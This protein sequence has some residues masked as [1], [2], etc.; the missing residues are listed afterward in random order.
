MPITDALAPY[1]A[2]PGLSLGIKTGVVDNNGTLT[3]VP[4]Q[5]L[6]LPANIASFVFYDAGAL[7]VSQN[8]SGFP[9]N[10]IPLCTATT[11]FNYISA[12]DDVRPD[13]IVGGG[14]SGGSL[15]DAQFNDGSGG[16]TNADGIFSGSIMAVDAISGEISIFDAGGSDGVF[17]DPGSGTTV[18]CSVSNIVSIQDFGGN[19]VKVGGPASAIDGLQLQATASS[20]SSIVLNSHTLGFYNATPV[21]KP[22]I[23]GAKAGNTAL[24][25]LITQLATLGL[26]TDSTT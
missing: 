5:T 6:T 9:A 19:W 2:G 25:S 23:T 3:I 16:L 15:G 21:V 8:T 11:Q 10:C 26:V 14:G 13:F 7:I 12:F 22:A 4:A 1:I 17:V 18:S 20:T 24:A